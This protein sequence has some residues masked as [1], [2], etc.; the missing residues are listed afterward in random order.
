MPTDTNIEKI[1]NSAV[2]IPLQYSTPPTVSTADKSED[3]MTNEGET[4]KY[5]L[6]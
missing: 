1:Y 6:L 4:A 5:I 3:N 2:K